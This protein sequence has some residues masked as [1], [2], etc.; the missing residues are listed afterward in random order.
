MTKA[1]ASVEDQVRTL[2]ADAERC[3]RFSLN[4]LPFVVENPNP[5]TRLVDSL[6]AEGFT[7]TKVGC[8]EGGCGSCTVM[9]SSRDP[10][11]QGTVHR[12]VNACL[13]PSCA[14]D[15]MD[16]SAA[17]TSARAGATATALPG[18]AAAG[19]MPA[20]PGMAGNE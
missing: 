5:A 4:S 13:R 19:G 11:G 2:F 10:R 15:G 8:G 17:H 16:A 20:M 14:V 7:G 3:L 18:R 12:A 1:L 9:L 6:R